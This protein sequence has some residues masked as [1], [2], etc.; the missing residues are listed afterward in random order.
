MVVCL[1]QVPNAKGPENIQWSVE[2]HPIPLSRMQNELLDL[3]YC[4]FDLGLQTHFNL[5]FVIPPI[6]ITAQ[7]GIPF[8]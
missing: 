2:M 5:R 1:P 7:D 8:G 3:P 6:Q 4:I